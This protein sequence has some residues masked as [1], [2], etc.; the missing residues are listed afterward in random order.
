MIE[1][2][3]APELRGDTSRPSKPY[4]GLRPFQSDEW[5]IFFGR[6]PMTDRVIDLLIENKIVVVHGDFWLRQILAYSSWRS[7]PASAGPRCHRRS[8]ADRG[9]VAPRG[10]AR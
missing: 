3:G 1:F 7:G 4:P 8:L 10:P 9:D 5:P 2:V 6:E